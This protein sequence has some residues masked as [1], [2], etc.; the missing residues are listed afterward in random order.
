MGRVLR[1]AR[2]VQQIVFAFQSSI[3][4]LFWA[5]VIVFLVLYCFGV[6]FL[7]GATDALFAVDAD[8]SPSNKLLIDTYFSTLVRSVY[9]L[10]MSITG[11]VSWGDVLTPFWSYGHAYILIFIVFVS[12]TI[13]GL[14][15][16]VTAIFVD[17][18][19]QSQQHD[20]D[21]MIQ[22]KM[23][24]KDRVCQHL[25]DLFRSIDADGSGYINI[26]EMDRVLA[27]PNLNIYMESMEIFSNDAL[28]LFRL[29]DTDNIGSVNIE[30]FCEGC[31]KLKG[32]ARSFDIHF[33]M[34]N[35]ER[36]QR[37]LD[38]IAKQLTAFLAEPRTG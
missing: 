30:E 26:E 12:V 23:D 10:F 32:E 16:V 5:M 18:A 8:P 15:N 25:K 37:K 19:M 3:V 17:S 29:L 14:L 28:A 7:M 20:K 4:T 35:N 21:L 31:M 13:F 24:K 36:C 11:G 22:E 38:R 27:D 34:Y 9:T 1:H 6:T 33:L 2:T